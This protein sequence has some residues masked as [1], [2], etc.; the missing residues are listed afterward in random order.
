MDIAIFRTA[1]LA[2]L[3]D[4]H[5]PVL[6]DSELK[7][8]M[9]PGLLQRFLSYFTREVKLQKRGEDMLGMAGVCSY[10]KLRKSIRLRYYSIYIKAT[11]PTGL[12]LSLVQNGV[13]MSS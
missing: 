10:N 9:I 12:I 1:S 4:K 2:S 7:D 13:A 8:R 6:I 11:K 3:I 5:P